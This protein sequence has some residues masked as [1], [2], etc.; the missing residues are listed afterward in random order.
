MIVTEYSI[1]S[2]NTEVSAT[3]GHERAGTSSVGWSGAETLLHET[4]GHDLG[5]M[6]I[7][8]RLPHSRGS[9]WRV[10]EGRGRRWGCQLLARP[11]LQR[12]TCRDHKV[13]TEASIE[14]AHMTLH[15]RPM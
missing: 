2:Y 5:A 8:R 11:A 15:R 6:G 10:L 13:A 9:S 4:A 1:L 12:R 3:L 7:W 14:Q